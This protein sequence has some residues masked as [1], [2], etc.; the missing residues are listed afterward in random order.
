MTLAACRND[1]R[2]QSQSTTSAQTY[3]TLDNNGEKIRW[4]GQK[5]LPGTRI[6]N[7]SNG[8]PGLVGRDFVVTSSA[9]PYQQ[10]TPQYT[11]TQIAGDN[12]RLSATATLDMASEMA[13]LKAMPEL[14]L[15]ELQIDYSPITELP[16]Y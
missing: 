5:L 12:Y 11:I 10:L 8:E 16:Q 14:T 9:L 13:R 6:D 1:E 4:R 2:D 7:L 15:I 3:F